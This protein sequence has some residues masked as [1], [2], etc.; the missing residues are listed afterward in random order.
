MSAL[1]VVAAAVRLPDGRVF[2]LPSPARHHDVI[3]MLHRE[4]G[5][6]Q[7]GDHEQGFLLSDGRFCRRAPAKLVAERAGQL[8]PR[9]MHLKDLY[10]EDVW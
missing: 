9:A 6:E 3:H 5:I 10:S 1:I 8:L 2:S 4:H 7:R